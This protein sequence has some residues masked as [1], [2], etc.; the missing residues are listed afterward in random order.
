MNKEIILYRSKNMNTK[1][2]EKDKD[3]A[4]LIASIAGKSAAST[5]ASSI[6]SG[7]VSNML[8]KD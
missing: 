4:N 1:E 7:I 5:V 6:V 3:L 2:F 8:K